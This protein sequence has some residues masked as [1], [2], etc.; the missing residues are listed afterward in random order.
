MAVVA[1]VLVMSLFA[2]VLWM[3][4][5]LR[6]RGGQVA[7]PQFP[8][9]PVSLDIQFEA[10]GDDER[11]EARLAARLVAGDLPAPDYRCAMEVLAAQ[12][13]ARR[14]IVVPPDSAH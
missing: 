3:P 11:A 10:D 14:P 1:V 8:P 7:A 2:V 4:G 9:M 12:D 6:D 5:W 13:A